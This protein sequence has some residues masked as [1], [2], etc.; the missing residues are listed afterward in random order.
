M[1]FNGAILT[2]LMFCVWS[3]LSTKVF[4]QEADS[5]LDS[6]LGKKSDNTQIVAVMGFS[7]EQ[8]KKMADESKSLQGSEEFIDNCISFSTQNGVESQQKTKTFVL[9]DVDG[10]KNKNDASVETQ[11]QNKEISR[12]PAKSSNVESQ[13]LPSESES[14]P[15]QILN[16]SEAQGG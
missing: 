13:I 6:I 11:V 5:S 14:T 16:E 4:A 2:I 12:A 7:Y 3:F 9:E 1:R 8:C 15:L 10:T